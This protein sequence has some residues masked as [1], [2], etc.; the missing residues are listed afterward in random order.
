M[1]KIDEA[2]QKLLRKIPQMPQNYTDSM[3]DFFGQDVSNSTPVQAYKAK[4]T[5]DMADRWER[6]LKKRYGIR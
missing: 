4:V 2:K 3:S 5:P 6:N 1:A